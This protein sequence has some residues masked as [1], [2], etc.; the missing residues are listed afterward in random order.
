MGRAEGDGVTSH[1]SG[2][3]A[4]PWHACDGLIDHGLELGFLLLPRL[5]ELEPAGSTD[6]VSER[7]LE[8]SILRKHLLRHGYPADR[9]IL[10]GAR[11]DPILL[12]ELTV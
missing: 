7:L 6:L 10:G 1:T 2:T 12:T 11:T 5:H 8:A 4:V 9:L 3:I